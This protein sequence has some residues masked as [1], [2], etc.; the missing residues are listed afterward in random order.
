M[1]PRPASSGNRQSTPTAEA[2]RV[3]RALSTAS[4]VGRIFLNL[5]DEENPMGQWAPNNVDLDKY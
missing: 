4:A 5:L 3:N 2:R 1:S